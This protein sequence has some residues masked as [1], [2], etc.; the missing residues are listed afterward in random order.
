MNYPIGNSG[1]VAQKDVAKIHTDLGVRMFDLTQDISGVVGFEP[2]R[3]ERVAMFL[4]SGVGVNVANRELSLVSVSPL[5]W[6]L[7]PLEGDEVTIDVRA[8]YTYKLAKASVSAIGDKITS[9]NYLMF[10]EAPDNS[11]TAGTGTDRL[12]TN[13]PKN[14]AQE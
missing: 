11:A 13:L 3:D 12:Y 9:Y 14:P 2:I 8:G 7:L 10:R 1:S 4:A 5:L 6:D